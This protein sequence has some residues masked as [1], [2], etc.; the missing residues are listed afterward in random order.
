[1]TAQ[2]G[3]TILLDTRNCQLLGDPHYTRCIHGLVDRK[4]APLGLPAGRQAIRQW[5]RLDIVRQ[6][7]EQQA[8]NAMRTINV[9]VTCR[10]FGFGSGRFRVG[11]SRLE[12]LPIVAQRRDMRRQALNR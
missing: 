9:R 10:V 8:C 1:M 12:G 6:S 5:P 3:G 7:V 11:K 2:T 4:P